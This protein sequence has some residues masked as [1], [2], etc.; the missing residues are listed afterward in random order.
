MTKIL[1]N[2][3]LNKFKFI[4]DKYKLLRKSVIHNDAND[5]NILVDENDLQSVTALIDYGDSVYSQ[6]IN[7][8]SVVLA[9]GLMDFEQPLEASRAIIAGYHKQ[10]PLFDDELQVLY[11]TTAMRLVIS[12]TKSAINK[13]KEPGNVYLLCSEKAAWSLLEKWQSIP[14]NLAYYS[15][16]SACGM[17]PCNKYD[18]FVEYSQN[19]VDMWSI[20]KLMPSSQSKNIG[21]LDLSV[22]SKFVGNFKNYLSTEVISSNSILLNIIDLGKSFQGFFLKKNERGFH[23]YLRFMIPKHSK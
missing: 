10:M 17:T 16:R 11:V 22:S 18:A 21:T 20:E 14:A 23:H 9:Y 5:N 15:F 3:L 13:K 8:L 12:V 19:V 6:T 4:Q 1:N 7:D 2:F